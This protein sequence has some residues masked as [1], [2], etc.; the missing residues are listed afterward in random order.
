MKFLLLLCLFSASTAMAE[1]LSDGCQNP[2]WDQTYNQT[3]TGHK[4]IFSSPNYDANKPHKLV[5]ELHG[6]GMNADWM[7]SLAGGVEAFSTDTIFTYLDAGKQGWD[8][9][10]ANLIDNVIDQMGRTYCVDLYQVFVAGYSNGAFFAN[11]LG[12]RKSDKI[13]AIIAVA[14]GGGGGPMIP[15]M[16][17]HGR[18]DQYVSFGSGFQ[19]MKNWAYSDKCNTPTSDDG[20]VGCQYL[21]GCLK[22]VVW[23]PW[24]GNHDWPSWLH[25][26]V[27]QFIDNA[28]KR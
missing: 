8:W 11:M 18:S 25:K 10:D 6:Y 22:Q 19:A 21:P 27:W 14:G 3:V 13:K 24:N 5:I 12:Q 9:S 4:I 1:K 20:H 23:C 7:K 28:S 16:I 15:A 17:V 26:D 2:S